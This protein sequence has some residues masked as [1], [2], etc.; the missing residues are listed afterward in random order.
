M[1]SAESARHLYT[2]SDVPKLYNEL[3]SQN[4]TL[5][6]KAPESRALI[7]RAYEIAK[8]AHGK[9]YRKSGEPYI[10]H[11][12]IVAKY[13]SK[14]YPGDIQMIL[15]AL[16][17]DVV[18]D[19]PKTLD[20]INQSFP[21]TPEL[22]QIV[23][24]VTKLNV[25]NDTEDSAQVAN[26]RKLISQTIN[27]NPR[28]ILIKL[29]DR[30]HNMQTLEF[31]AQNK[32]Q[33]IASETMFFYVPIAERLGLYSIKT[34]LEDLSFRYLNPSEYRE[35]QELFDKHREKL[36]A[37]HRDVKERVGR[38]LTNTGMT[39][40]L[41]S[42]EKTPY[43]TYKKI[44]T[45]RIPF[46]EIYDLIA[47]RIIFEPRPDI[48][49]QTQ[50]WFIYML[51]TEH[52]PALRER[53]RD[54]VSTPKVNG[55]EALHCT[56]MDKNGQWVEVQI[57]SERMNKIAEDGGASHWRYKKEAEVDSDGQLGE[58][59]SSL[60]TLVSSYSYEMSSSTFMAYLKTD[61]LEKKITVY[62]R[63]LSEKDDEGL[64]RLRKEFTI[65]RDSRVLDFAY[66]KD[67]NVGDHALGA[68]VNGILTSLDYKLLAGDEV[69]IISAS[70]QYP[71][72]GWKEVAQTSLARNLI[73][74]ALEK[75]DDSLQE[76]GRFR[77]QEMFNTLDVAYSEELLRKLL[78]LFEEQ[79][80][81]K[82]YADLANGY[83]NPQYLFRKI[84]RSVHKEKFT[85]SWSRLQGYFMLHILRRH[86][87]CDTVEH[88][89]SVERANEKY[90]LLT[91]P[92]CCAL[93]GD[94][95]VFCFR[96]LGMRN[97]VVR[98]HKS[99]CLEAQRLS[100]E[101]GNLLIK[102]IDWSIKTEASY[103][104]HIYVGGEDRTNLLIELFSIFMKELPN[105]NITRADLRSDGS[106]FQGVLSFSLQHLNQLDMLIQ[107]LYRI[108]GIQRIYRLDVPSSYEFVDRL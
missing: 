88:Q 90:K 63:I 12:I 55:Y 82:L 9:Q 2:D 46:E 66:L 107:R 22:V 105:A 86:T 101:H 79:N 104:T 62:E 64:S 37:V 28:I 93:P 94:K 17:H 54:W 42:R 31:Q 69:E 30:L 73:N 5:L 34:E 36:S 23:D 96:E 11:P 84:R 78:P 33:K 61:L 44:S 51:L 38:L 50:C 92:C 108:E 102:D 77:L 75:Q 6:E 29:A 74:Q 3:L 13:A 98:V 4:A 47:L 91:S 40:T 1:Q 72:K 43:S 41:L 15:A 49:E 95:D 53:T 24:G 65:P 106:H 26:F 56:L 67:K 103:P 10:I 45:K 48:P 35:I 80:L 70:S 60:A 76:R 68:R 14:I 18:E 32:R 97:N 16:L 27:D 87:S 52:F 58:V 89:S 85:T 59:G 71:T 25:L 100:S 7:D 83:I 81:D 19:S 39:F 57:R 20:D 99:N 8:V 21:E